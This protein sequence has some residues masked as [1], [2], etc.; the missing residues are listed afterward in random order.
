MR[1]ER[2]VKRNEKTDR[3]RRVKRREREEIRRQRDGE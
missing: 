1:K 2:K 3:E